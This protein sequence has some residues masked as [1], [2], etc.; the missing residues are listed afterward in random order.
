M[1]IVKVIGFALLT[2]VSASPQSDVANALDGWGAVHWGMTLADAKAALGEKVIT[3]DPPAKWGGDK[4][5]DEL[6]ML[7]I[8]PVEIRGMAFKVSFGFSSGR[9]SGVTLFSSTRTEDPS[10]TPL[11]K[12]RD[13]ITEKYGP[14]TTSSKQVH[15]DGNAYLGA[16][17]ALKKT[18]ITVDFSRIVNLNSLTIYYQPARH[19]PNL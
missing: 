14:P 18:A 8:P 10:M 19:E 7:A 5:R 4:W 6:E 12:I 11:E 1:R 16:T 13:A 17:W 2:A 15:P 9:L 3:L